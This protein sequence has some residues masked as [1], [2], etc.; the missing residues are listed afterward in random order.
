MVGV[1]LFGPMLA[2]NVAVIRSRPL[3]VA[4]LM[5]RASRPAMVT[6]SSFV[7]TEGSSG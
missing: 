1:G 2:I 4:V 5:V 3:L 6:S 7:C